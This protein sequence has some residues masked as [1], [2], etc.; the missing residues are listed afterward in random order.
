MTVRIN[1]L[2]TS[3]QGLQRI[4]GNPETN[5]AERTSLAKGLA[6][7]EHL[8]DFSCLTTNIPTRSLQLSAHHATP[9]LNFGNDSE[10]KVKKETMKIPAGLDSKARKISTKKQQIVNKFS[11]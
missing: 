11:S 9:K 5:C 6:G 10:L 7:Q 2:D 4:H 3:Q 1:R 8:F